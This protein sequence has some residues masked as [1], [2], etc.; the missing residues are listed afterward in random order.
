MRLRFKFLTKRLKFPQIRNLSQNPT[1]Q[2]ESILGRVSGNR[3]SLQAT[4]KLPLLISNFKG[5]G[6]ASREGAIVPDLPGF[7]GLGHFL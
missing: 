7:M 4:V 2:D 6:L 5:N 1:D 3:S